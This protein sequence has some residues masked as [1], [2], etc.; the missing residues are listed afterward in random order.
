MCKIMD[1]F[2]EKSFNEGKAE[3]R[4]EGQLEERLKILK[5][6]MFNLKTSV[7]E[8]A[9]IIGISEAEVEEYKTLLLE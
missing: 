7:T 3:G 8:A 2:R 6:V 4:A 9:K 1:E 5:T